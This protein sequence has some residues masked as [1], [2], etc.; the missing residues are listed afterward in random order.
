MTDVQGKVAFITGGAN[1]IGLGVARRLTEAGANVTIADV[2]DAAGEAAATE[3]GGHY[4]HCDV[5]E[6][7]ACQHAVDEAVARW[8]KLDIAHL[9]AGITT[10]CGVG[11]DFDLERYRRA[12]AINLDGVVFGLQAA[13]P[14]LRAGNGGQI[15]C[16]SSLA[17]LVAVPGEPFYAANK[18]AVVGLVR[19]L[20]PV[21]APENILINALCPG[22]ANT[23]I[24]DDIR[25][26]LASIQVPI[27]PVAEVV[28]AFMAI[29]ASDEGGQCW[30]VQR[31]RTSEPFRFR[32]APGP[33]AEND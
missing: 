6:L 17:G 31:G 7:D 33:R 19:S 10:G 9:N 29:L 24:I 16:T 11:V 25:E 2:D 32:G 28:E 14:A 20:G 22:F 12:M 1:G 13:L 21:L 26:L 27:I 3:L 18:H 4:V 8:G 23:A 15:V 30:P 5:R